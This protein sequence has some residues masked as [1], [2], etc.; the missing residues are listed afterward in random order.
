MANSLNKQV[1]NEPNETDD[2]SDV[3][4]ELLDSLPRVWTRGLLY[5]LFIFVSILLPWMMLFQV[6]E[7]G[8]ARGRLEPQGKTVRLDTIVAGTVSEVLV[9]EGDTVKAGQSLLVLDSKLIDADLQQMQEKLN[10]QLKQLSQLKLLQNQFLLALST[11]QQ[12]NKA[13]ELE[14]QVQ[15]DQTRQNIQALINSSTFQ[16]EEKLAQLNQVQQTLIQSEKASQSSQNSLASAQREVERY[17]EALKEGIVAEINVI[18]KKDLAQERQKLYEKAK[19]DIEQAR[20]RIVEEKNSYQRTIRQGNADIKQAQLRFK[21]QQSSYESL[22]N[23]GKLA[24]LKTQEQLKNI[25][26]EITTTN[27][28]IAQN[29]THIDSL[30][31]QLEQ[32]VLKAPVNGMVFQLPMQRP[33]GVVQSGT[34]IVE[35]APANSPLIIRANMATNQSSSLQKGLAVKVKFDAYPFQDY[36]VVEGKLAQIS[37]TTTEV[38]TSNGKVPAY[39]L[40]IILNQNCISTHNKCI[41]LRPGDTA[42][43]EVIVRQRRIIDFILDPFKQLQNGGFKL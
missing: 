5:L 9:K 1:I 11:Q 31:F 42:I 21:E 41:P 39:K 43:A 3:T 37:P 19:S 14:K 32:R 27:T 25:E 20:L 18:E 2:W 23:S 4:Q 36:G 8:T 15:I 38:N 7:T 12:Q 22:T 35:I 40:E 30:K 13:Q 26:R 6:D 10:G 24:I 29:K 33:G 16:K 28:E 17:Q 34:M